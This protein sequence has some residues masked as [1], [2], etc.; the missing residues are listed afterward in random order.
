MKKTFSLFDNLTLIKEEKRKKEKFSCFHDNKKTTL[1][2]NE[3][4][5]KTTRSFKYDENY[6]VILS[7]YTYS[8]YAYV[9]AAYSIKEK[10]LLFLDDYELSYNLDYMY[11]LKEDF[12]LGYILE[13]I[14]D[15]YL[16]FYDDNVLEDSIIFY[17]TSGNFNITKEEV[18][19][20]V[21]ECYPKLKKYTN[22]P[23]NLNA[24]DYSFIID[25]IG[26]I[27]LSFYKM[28]QTLE[29]SKKK[30]RTRK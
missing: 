13:L 16:G 3:Y 7:K 22:L 11:A 30:V 6:V 27:T 1:L 14:N 12:S 19:K 15:N 21:L 2:D 26:K 18:R 5:S 20:Y 23:C 24:K 28:P 29:S 10:E 9:E 8:D 25:E 17:L 4:N